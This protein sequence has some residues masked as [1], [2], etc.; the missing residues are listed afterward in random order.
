[1]IKVLR[2]AAIMLAMVAQSS[3]AAPIVSGLANPIYSGS[4]EDLA[5]DMQSVP[6]ADT[7]FHDLKSVLIEVDAF[8]FFARVLYHDGT[9]RGLDEERRTLTSIGLDLDRNN[10][11]GS[12]TGNDATLQIVSIAPL[13]ERRPR[14]LSW[15]PEGSL[16]SQ[17]IDEFSY[18]EFSNGFEVSLARDLLLGDGD[19]L[20]RFA[21]SSS[22]RLS[23]NSST[24]II[25]YLPVRGSRLEMT[26]VAQVPEPG[27]LALFS[28]G[29]AGL[30]AVRRRKHR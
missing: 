11:T 19:G 28:L 18:T 27:S 16:T 23:D 24:G 26:R 9:F 13:E 10:D 30:M 2:Y 29:L 3:L 17:R 22:Q 21:L 1:M 8:T 5:G 4:G 7:G 15:S 12:S 6:R 20:F 25:D 14:I